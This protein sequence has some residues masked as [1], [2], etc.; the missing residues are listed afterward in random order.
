MLENTDKERQPAAF[1]LFPLDN[2]LCKGPQG[3][4]SY[5]MVVEVGVTRELK[6]FT[7][8]AAASVVFTC[9]HCNSIQHHG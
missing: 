2:C 1:F 3:G 6:G 7:A 4:Q 9:S 8:A 5:L